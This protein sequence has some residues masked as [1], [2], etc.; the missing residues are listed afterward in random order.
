M[1]GDNDAMTG[2]D[3]TPRYYTPT[4]ELPSYA[5]PTEPNQTAQRTWRAPGTGAGRLQWEPLPERDTPYPWEIGRPIEAWQRNH[6]EIPKG[7]LPSAPA[8]MAPPEPA[9]P[10]PP[11]QIDPPSTATSESSAP[12]PAPAPA[13]TGRI[14][15]AKDTPQVAPQ[16]FR[17]VDRRVS[18]APAQQ[19]QQTA[20]PADPRSVDFPPPRG[21]P[22]QRPHTSQPGAKKGTLPFVSLLLPLIVLFDP[23]AALVPLI[24]AMLLIVRSKAYRKPGARVAWGVAVIAITVVFLVIR[25]IAV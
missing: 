11:V 16:P 1:S 5:E 10:L 12:T 25:A 22:V 17:T 4:Y 15:Y 8:P 9:A 7:P 20:H 23:A 3:T 19:R 13:N 2:T 6:R 14:P 21:T 24:A 18:Q